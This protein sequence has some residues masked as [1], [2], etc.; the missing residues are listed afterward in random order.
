MLGR[1]VVTGVVASTAGTIR[2]QVVDY[3]GAP[4]SGLKICPTQHKANPAQ[5]T[6]GKLVGKCGVTD[7]HGVA[8]LAKVKP[9]DRWA[10]VYSS[11]QGQLSH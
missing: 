5:K 10:T 11:G 8:L 9:G 2:V 4:Y 3:S 1:A 6:N 7:K